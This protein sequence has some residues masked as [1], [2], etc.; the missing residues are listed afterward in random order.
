[1]VLFLVYT[2]EPEVSTIIYLFY[3]C[4]LSIYIFGE[5]ELVFNALHAV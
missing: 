1:M 5:A 2:A 4:C 3:Y